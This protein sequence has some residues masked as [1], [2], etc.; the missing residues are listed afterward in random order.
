MTN[1]MKGETQIT[2]AKN[3]YSCRLTVDSLIKIETALDKGILQITQ[4]LSDGDVRL[5][6]LAVVLYH[7]LRGGGNNFSEKDI[8]GLIQD[9]GIVSCCGAV[10]QLLVSTLSDPSAESDEKK[11]EPES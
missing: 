7:A 5:N 9:S 10:A 6:D 1:P 2:L 11:Q 8:K 3:E 4:R